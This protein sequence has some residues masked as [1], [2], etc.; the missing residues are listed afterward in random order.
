MIGLRFRKP[1]FDERFVEYRPTMIDDVSRKRIKIGETNLTTRTFG[2]MPKTGDY[3]EVIRHCFGGTGGYFIP[4]RMSWDAMHRED[5]AIFD[6]DLLDGWSQSSIPPLTE[7]QVY[8]PFLDIARDAVQADNPLRKNVFG[9]YSLVIV[10]DNLK[11][12]AET[13]SDIPASERKPVNFLMN[14]IPGS[15]PFNKR[16]FPGEY[17]CLGDSISPEDL[18]VKAVLHPEYSL[19]KVLFQVR[20]KT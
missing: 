2:L 16:N 5:V 1:K 8:N 6:L 4:V 3:V 15:R 9:K 14:F 10:D 12:R 19:S 18:V 17:P 11:V 20:P 7:S 13:S